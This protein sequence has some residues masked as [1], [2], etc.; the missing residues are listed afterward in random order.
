MYRV[1]SFRHCLCVKT[2]VLVVW[3]SCECWYQLLFFSIY[4]YMLLAWFLVFILLLFAFSCCW[5]VILAMVTVVAL[6][7][8]TKC[9]LIFYVQL[10]G[11]HPICIRTPEELVFLLIRWQNKSQLKTCAATYIVL[12]T[13]CS[14]AIVNN[15][16]K[17]LDDAFSVINAKISWQR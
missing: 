9:C 8:T 16:V 17:K 2:F 12:H 6:L 5:V 11:C 7:S 10:V 4:T 1:S 15:D 13:D 14:H 3:D